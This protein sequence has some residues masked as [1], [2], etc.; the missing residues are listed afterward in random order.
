[1]EPV[2]RRHDREALTAA[3]CDQGSER[4]GQ[5]GLPGPGRPGEPEQKALARRIDGRE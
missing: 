3:L 1:V 5:G 4:L 2:Q